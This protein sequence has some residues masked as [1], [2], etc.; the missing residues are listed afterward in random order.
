MVTIAAGASVYLDT[1]ALI[2]ITEGSAAFKASMEGLLREA[3]AV[4][5]TLV[6]SE[7]ALTE[8]LVAPMRDRNRALLDAYSELFDAFVKAVPVERAILMRAAQLR[9]DTIR[10]RTPD[11]IHLATAQFVGAALFVT[12]DARISV[13]SPMVRRLL[14]PD[15]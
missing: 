13:S 10:L 7:L 4:K 15:G 9:A 6:T 12:G 1:N 8:V 5:A 3:L 14:R 11:A 2:Y